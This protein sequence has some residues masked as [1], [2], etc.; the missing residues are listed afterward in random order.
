MS[1]FVGFNMFELQITA[2]PTVLAEM[3]CRSSWAV[4]NASIPPS[5]S[6]SPRDY[7]PRSTAKDEIFI[8]DPV[9]RLG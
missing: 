5:L 7:R 3:W 9:N 6:T 1:V 4:Q 8:D 2:M